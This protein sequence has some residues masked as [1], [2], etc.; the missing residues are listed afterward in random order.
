M[1]CSGIAKSRPAKAFLVAALTGKFCSLRKSLSARPTA[2]ARVISPSGIPAKMSPCPSSV[3][4]SLT[5]VSGTTGGKGKSN[6]SASSSSL[7]RV[8]SCFSCATRS[9][10][11]ALSSAFCSRSKALACRS[12]EGASPPSLVNICFCFAPN[13][14]L[15]FSATVSSMFNSF[16]ESSLTGLVVSKATP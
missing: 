2:G 10:W 5:S 16:T 9:F 6:C 13:K 1:R 3:T 7:R 8:A 4:A 15:L 12:T 14:P 11:A